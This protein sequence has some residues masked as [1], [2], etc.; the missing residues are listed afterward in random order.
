MF[1][2][3]AQPENIKIECKCIDVNEFEHSFIVGALKA[4]VIFALRN[5][6]SARLLS[7]LSKKKEKVLL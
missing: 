7:L 2:K 5:Q 4:E 1:I 6:I 3:T